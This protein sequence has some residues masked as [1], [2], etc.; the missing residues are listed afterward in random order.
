M[1]KVR[2][3]P[4]I[5][6]WIF[7]VLATIVG[8]TARRLIWQFPEFAYLGVFSLATFFANG[9]LIGSIH[10]LLLRRYLQI[11]GWRSWISGL[12]WIALSGLGWLLTWS[13][14]IIF[15]TLYIL[16]AN[17]GFSLLTITLLAGGI[18][19]MLTGTL[20]ALILRRT[21]TRAWLWIPINIV[22]MAAA[23]FAHQNIPIIQ[24]SLAFAIGGLVF[25]ALSGTGLL[26]L[27]GQIKTIPSSISLPE[28]KQRHATPDFR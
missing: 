8:W 15:P 28:S 1:R 14:N 3:Q 9:L 26:Y 10:W 5:L 13:L 4:G 25:G 21:L 6:F 22:S 18:G 2:P 12:G 24:P 23:M 20:Q 11:G 7:W 19:S 16:V 17:A 27:F